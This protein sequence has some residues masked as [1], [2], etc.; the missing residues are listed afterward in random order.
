MIA[1]MNHPALLLALLSPLL[2]SAEGF[3]DDFSA[4]S[5]GS[6]GGPRWRVLRGEWKVRDKKLAQLADGEGHAIAAQGLERGSY[7]LEVRFRTVAGIPGEGGLLG[8]KG[9]ESPGPGHLVR[10][11]PEGLYY[12]SLDAS[13]EF[14]G[15]GPVPALVEGRTWNTLIIFVD[16][17]LGRYRVVFNGRRASEVQPLEHDGPGIGL[18]SNGGEHAFAL[19]AVE[20]AAENPDVKDEAPRT[21]SPRGDRGGNAERPKKPVDIAAAPGGDLLVLDREA[22]PV[23]VLRPWLYFNRIGA[24]GR[25]ESGAR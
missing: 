25:L 13:G 22:P 5:E 18:V 17:K 16:R 4:Y 3:R 2:P 1:V 8:L 21:P 14:R 12:G 7:R 23:M 6:S 10:V 11:D 24:F 20:P 15:E 9:G 19:C